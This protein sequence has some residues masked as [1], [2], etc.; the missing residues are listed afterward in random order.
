MITTVAI[1]VLHLGVAPQ[2]IVPKVRNVGHV[3]HAVSDQGVLDGLVVMMTKWLLNVP[4]KWTSVTS[5]I[6][7]LLH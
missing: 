2:G 7:P 1:V 5:T 4:L 3:I 6:V